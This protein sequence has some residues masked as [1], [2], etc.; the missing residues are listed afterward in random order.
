MDRGKL[1]RDQ[2][3]FN[4]ATVAHAFQQARAAALLPLLRSGIPL[5]SEQRQLD[6]HVERVKLANWID[7]ILPG[8]GW[9]ILGK[10]ALAAIRLGSA[11]FIA[12]VVVY[13]VKVGMFELHAPWMMS[14]T[15]AA[16]MALVMDSYNVVN[17]ALFVV[18]A[19]ALSEAGAVIDETLDGPCIVVAM[20]GWMIRYGYIVSSFTSIA[21]IAFTHRN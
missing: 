1:V 17:D 11:W 12:S 5:V 9:C 21:L 13:V 4:L 16:F 6:G 15:L 18:R 3:A 7:Y 2:P 10:P 19:E 8:L 20:I 14:F